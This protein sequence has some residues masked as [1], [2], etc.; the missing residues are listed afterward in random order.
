MKNLKIFALIVCTLFVVASCDES[1]FLDQQNPNTIT[2]DTF[3]KSTTDFQSALTTVYAAT[4]F[5]SISGAGLA[6]EYIMADLSGT[7]WW[8]AGHFQWNNLAF[9]NAQPQVREKW[10]D[11]YVGIF[12]ANQVLEALAETTIEDLTEE[13]KLLMEGQAKFLRAFFYFQVAHTFGGAVIHTEVPKSPEE[14]TKPFSSIQEVTDQVLIPDLEFAATSLPQTWTGNDVGRATWGAAK[15]MLGKTH[16]FIGS[17]AE[18][19][20]EFKEVIDAGVYSLVPDILD[21]FTS[22][23][24]HNSESIFEVVYSESL[25]PGVG[26]GLHDNNPQAIGAEATTIISSMAT[27]DK[28]GFHV[29]QPTYWMHELF[30]FDEPDSLDVKNIDGGVVYAQSRRMHASIVDQ[31]SD[32]LYYEDDANAADAYNGGQSAYTK[33]WSNWYDRAGELTPFKSGIN[34]RHIRYADVLLMYA[35]AVLE[36]D[37]DFETA[38]DYIDMVRERAGVFTLQ[39]YLDANSNTFPEFHKPLFASIGTTRS[40]VAPSKESVL[41]HLRMVERPLELYAEGHRFKD[42]A[43]WG[44]GVEV[45]Q[46]RLNEEISR[47]DTDIIDEHEALLD[48]NGPRNDFVVKAARYI[49]N[50]EVLKYLPI[51]SQEVQ[52]NPSLTSGN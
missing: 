47:G 10:A 16:L 49:A 1:D 9:T 8:H 51:P 30:I 42:L 15:T 36:A 44:I 11:L 52:A 29:V 37:N 23:N 43:R 34:H 5:E 27:Q 2:P 25:V 20:D 22:L 39:E 18:A 24:E 40:Y 48:I 14:F 26:G 12:R 50:P 33:K 19:R 13:D 41:T 7:N 28:G 17:F 46:A 32:G 3:W 45:F 38:I 6:Y 21:N 31:N 4:Q 35:E